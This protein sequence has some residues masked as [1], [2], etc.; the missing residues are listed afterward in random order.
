MKPNVE[1]AVGKKAQQQLGLVSRGQALELGI[2]RQ[3]IH[4]H[5]KA[6]R[7]EEVCKHVYRLAGTPVSDHQRILAVCLSL[8]PRAF[9]SHGTAAFLWGLDGYSKS[10]P[11]P[12]E[13]SAPHGTTRAFRGV[14]VHQRR[15]LVLADPAAFGLV[16][17]TP[18]TRTI[19]DLAT[20]LDAAKLERAFDSA[21]R[22]APD[23]PKELAAYLEDLG[24]DGR[25]GTHILRALVHARQPRPT[26]SAHEVDVLRTLRRA[27]L[28]EPTLQHAIRDG[29]GL[30]S[31]A[32]FAW[33]DQKV[34]L[35]ADGW[36]YHHSH[37]SFDRDR[38][39]RERL[40]AHGWTPVV[41]TPRTMAGGS[42]L[43]SLSRHLSKAG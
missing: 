19:V 13:V 6:K 2:S 4:R 7:W 21:W 18:L 43:A 39:Q 32:D 37:A 35:F 1:V 9:A 34:V 30:I 25:R 23:L 12:F 31:I 40:A 27:R 42:W 38:E 15:D 28:P 16:P 11:R 5:C 33:V 22:K 8:G 29:R 41:V 24:V 26:D 3:A 10:M 20:V 17:T 36:A 14:I